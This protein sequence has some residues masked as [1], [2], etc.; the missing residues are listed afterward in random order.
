MTDK[1]EIVNKLK[2][3]YTTP[4]KGQEKN[5]KA[6]TNWYDNYSLLVDKYNNIMQNYMAYT[7][8]Q[9]LINIYD[10]HNKMPFGLWNIYNTTYPNW[11]HYKVIRY[12]DHINDLYENLK[13]L[14]PEKECILAYDNSFHKFRLVFD[15]QYIYS[16]VNSYIIYKK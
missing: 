3:E 5:F 4:L 7:K 13:N 14:L 8:K 10:Y 1:I 11:Y 6:Y 9:L 2:K 12:R 16:D 15:W